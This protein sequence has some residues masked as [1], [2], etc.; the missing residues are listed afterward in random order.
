[1]SDVNP[2]FPCAA[3]G[4]IQQGKSLSADVDAVNNVFAVSRFVKKYF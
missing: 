3:Y 4:Y 1:V 2:S